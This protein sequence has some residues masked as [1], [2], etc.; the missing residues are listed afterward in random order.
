MLTLKAFRDA[1]VRSDLVRLAVGLALGFAL[2]RL[3]QMI[4]F[5]LI[6][7]FIALFVGEPLFVLNSIS[8]GDVEFRYATVIEALI[9]LS[10]VLVL[11][12]YLVLRPAEQRALGVVGETRSCPECTSS[13]S[14][15]AKRCPHCT[16]AVQ[17]ASD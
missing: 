1:I 13:I 10:L 9:S 17:P 15:R 14:V 4:V 5:N 2:F 7:P 12:H 11:A 8:V 16:S 3:A 6:D